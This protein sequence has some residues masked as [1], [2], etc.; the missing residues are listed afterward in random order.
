MQRAAIKIEGDLLVFGGPYGNLEAT[1]AL[2]AEGARLG[3]PP[4]RIVCTGDLA[5]YCAHP[6]GTI[7]LVR[8]A[9][10]HVVMGNCDEQLAVGAADCACGYP[11]GGAC[12][13]LASAWF[14]YAAARSDRRPAHGSP[15]CRAG[16]M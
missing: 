1:E 14:P 2:L 12:E 6:A 4:E 8:T 15:P 10:I 7:D 13:R 16:S 11:A 9:G 3:I 5:A